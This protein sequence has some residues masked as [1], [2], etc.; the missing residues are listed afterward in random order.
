M[1]YLLYSLFLSLLYLPISAQIIV[2]AGNDTIVM[3][4]SDTTI[5]ELGGIPSVS[6]G[7]PPYNYEWSIKNPYI[8]FPGSPLTFYASDFLN[9]TTLS[10]PIIT[11]GFICEKMMF[12]LKVTDSVGNT[13]IDSC[14]VMFSVYITNLWYWNYGIWHGDSIY[15]NQGSNV[16]GGI[17]SLTYLWKPNHGLTDSTS[18]S[19]WAKPDTTI[20]Y[21]VTVTDSVGCVLEAP[22]L[23]YVDVLHVGIGES[24]T[25]DYVKIYPNP[26]NDFLFI[27][28]KENFI[29]FFTTI[30]DMNGKIVFNYKGYIEKI[31]TSDL[32]QGV[33]LLELKTEKGIF[34]KKILI[35]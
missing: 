31:Q 12:Y 25:L 34:V 17:G 4:T 35:E 15:L 2:D 18:L 24:E 8:A 11:D 13:G 1:K 7:V 5:T 6:N 32:L 22:P 26:T 21:Y 30:T 9:D 10:N 28:N 33:Y 14:L 29:V 3:C 19:F 16:G 20:A 27:A 23:Y